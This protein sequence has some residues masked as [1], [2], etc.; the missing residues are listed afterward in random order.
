MGNRTQKH[1]DYHLLREERLRAGWSQ[2]DLADRLGTTINNV[3]RWELGQT[4]PGPY[5]REKLSKLFGKSV[6]DL[7][8]VGKGESLPTAESE[9]PKATPM[10]ASSLEEEI[11]L[12]TV[13]YRRNPHFTG[14]DE[15]L[16]QLEQQLSLVGSGDLKRTRSIALTQPQAIKGLGG[17]G[18]TQIAV[19]YAYR[20]REQGHYMHILWI[21]AASEEAILTSFATLAELHPAFSAGD[22][23]DQ[24]KLVR[25][26]K[27]WLEQCKERW[28]LIFDN[29]DNVAMAQEYFPRWGNGSILLTTR[30]NAVG[31]LAASIDVEK[32]G[33]V[34]GTH[35]LLS[36]AR[37]LENASE[38]E[39]NEAGNIVVA[40]DHFPLALDQAGAYIDETGC[41]FS[42]YL[43]L[44][45]DHRKVLLA[46]RGAQSSHYP[47][48]VAT[49]WCLSFRAVERANPAAG[50]F[51][52][53]CAFL[54]PDYIPEEL[55]TEGAAYWPPLLQQVTTDLLAFNQMFEN[56]LAFSAVKRLA[57]DH[58][59]S[60][61][62]LLQVILVDAMEP[63]E[64]HQWAERVVRAVN[65]VFPRD[66]KED[67]DSWPKCLRYLE[68]AQACD[69]LIQRYQLQLPEAA[70]LLDRTATYL[71][72]CAS[73]SL[74][75][76]LYLRSISLWEQRL[77]PDDPQVAFPLNNLARLYFLQG[78]YA[79]AE[80]F[81]LRALHIREQQL[82]PVH[83]LVA[84]PVTG[85]AN[86]YREQ[87]KYAEVELFYKRSLSIWEQARGPLH[88]NVARLLN[89][90]A[91][92]YQELGRYVEAEPLFQ[93]ALQIWE[94]TLG[95]E[96][97]D[98]A[99]SLNNLASLYQDLGKY[100]EAEPLYQR[101]LQIWEQTLGLDHP[102]AA[103]PLDNLANLYREQKKYAEAEPMFQRALRIREQ[104]HGPENP[105]VAYVL[106]NLAELYREQG[107]YEEAGP[108]YQRALHIREQYLGPESPL[109]A[110]PLIGLANLCR[111]QK[112]YAEAELFYQRALHIREQT[113][114]PQHPDMAHVLHELAAFREVQG[115]LQEAVSLYQRAFAIR[116][117]IYGPQHPKTIDT[118]NRLCA[119][120]AACKS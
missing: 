13:P 116:E 3:S 26:I 55:L 72:T 61:H 94:Q 75:E 45:Q 117:H 109:V 82:G 30:A 73:Y 67:S 63:E 96:Y 87:G 120:Q 12:W 74:A 105:I 58:R 44:Y 101:A 51:L 29:A 70:D 17:I 2:R 48:S 77:G 52:R 85:L 16:D 21:S 46:R 62:R 6:Q 5:F 54:A 100:A 103:Y 24:H 86:L 53:L 50:D 31:S 33:F 97:P 95:L 83:P 39:I 106:T 8:L 56:V 93:R 14:R 119:V 71:R 69:T 98:V 92:L 108:L 81:Y 68:Q 112:N 37:R 88:P 25:E 78:K 34:E 22:Q 65:T 102:N 38:E 107:R 76:P 27:R 7:G 19:E 20:S 111:E 84:P 41:S 57:E 79:E 110:A 115:N 59:L 91:S 64:Q 18:K 47:T 9:V 32:M 114:E 118:S 42:T 1:R 35:L 23:T 40:L 80:S 113:L 10:S 28:L 11:P 4:T 43:Q 15:I 89:N 99:R 90:L 60:I 36:R 66:P 49:T 104:A